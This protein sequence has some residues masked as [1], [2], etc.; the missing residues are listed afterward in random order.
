M[1]RNFMANFVHMTHP[2]VSIPQP[3]RILHI[4]SQ[5]LMWAHNTV[6]ISI[7]EVT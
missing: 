3:E 7:G 6:A 5:P 1:N 4:E 2:K